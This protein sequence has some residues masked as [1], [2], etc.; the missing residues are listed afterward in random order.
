VT[1]ALR[2]QTTLDTLSLYDLPGVHVVVEPFDLAAESDGLHGDSLRHAMEIKLQDAGIRVL[3]QD[4]WQ[5]TLG[6]PLLVLKLNLVHPSRFFY[7]YNIELELQQLVVL[8]RDSTIPV[9][10]PTWQAGDIVG[11]VP[12]SNLVS[13]R[14]QVLAAT[15]EFISA[16]AAAN[17]RRR[18]PSMFDQHRSAGLQWPL[19]SRP[20]GRVGP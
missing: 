7:L 13:L 4:E 1:G 14:S 2:A 15:D 9:F 8:A 12:A 16:L 3:T 18:S 10:T 6:N 19:A 11:T 17:R 5:V 20:E